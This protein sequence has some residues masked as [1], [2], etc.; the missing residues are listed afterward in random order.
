MWRTI[1]SRLWSR[2]SPFICLVVIIVTGYVIRLCHNRYQLQ[3]AEELLWSHPDSARYIIENIEDDGWLTN[4]EKNDCRL[5]TL[6]YR[7]RTGEYEKT[8][9]VLREIIRYSSS[10]ERKMV[11]ELYVGD[12]YIEIGLNDSAMAAL[13]RSES[14]LSEKCHP[15]Y[16]SLLYSNLGYLYRYTGGFEEAI[17]YYDLSQAINR[18]EGYVEWNIN[19]QLSMLN[20]PGYLKQ[21]AQRDSIISDLEDLLDTVDGSTQSK[22]LNNIGRHYELLQEYEVAFTYYQQ[23]IRCDWSMP[24]YRA[25]L[26]LGRLY[27]HRGHSEIADSLYR[28][29]EPCESEAVRLSLIKHRYI[30]ELNQL[31]DGGQ[32]IKQFIADMDAYYNQQLQTRIFE[33]RAAYE[34]ERVEKRQARVRNQLL[35]IILLLLIA[36]RLSIICRKHELNRLVGRLREAIIRHNELMLLHK[37]DNAIQ[38][39][40]LQQEIKTLMGKI[41]QYKMIFRTSDSYHELTPDDLKAMNWYLLLRTGKDTY[42][43]KQDRD[44]LYRWTNITENDFVQRLKEYH[45]ELAPLELDLCCLVRLG[46]NTS[47]ISELTSYEPASLKR[48]LRKIYPV[49]GVNSKEE[50]EGYVGRF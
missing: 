23:A 18:R 29:V 20:I 16:V 25:Y 6:V 31:P 27:E 12:Y 49:F 30:K 32:T 33:L 48:M 40:Q 4:R 35:I 8:D 47:Q 45:P 26:N 1:L 24:P 39:G 5:L 22:I 38:V 10:R 44:Q 7:S 9:S 37:E 50:F 2:C 41:N 17:H 13:N 14:Y 19:N 21:P 11:G 42:H 43:P 46:F 34:K 3:Q 15:R 28:L 36:F